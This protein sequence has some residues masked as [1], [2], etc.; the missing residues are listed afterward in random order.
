MICNLVRRVIG[1]GV[2]VGVTIAILVAVRTEIGLG[3]P[4]E[5][6]EVYGQPL[7]A[8]VD[9]ALQEAAG[10]CVARQSP[11]IDDKD[12]ACQPSDGGVCVV[13]GQTISCPWVRITEVAQG[14]DCVSETY[15]VECWDC[16]AF[17]CARD[18]LYLTQAD[19]QA[20]RDRICVGSKPDSYRTCDP[21]NPTQGHL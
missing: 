14:G 10:S 9:A 15:G 18:D 21:Q 3:G 7:R 5:P 11:C 19:C 20:E 13:D 12:G 2:G 1:P 8:C 17:V 16:G 4:P 6:E